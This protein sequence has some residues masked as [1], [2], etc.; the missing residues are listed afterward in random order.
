MK[1][2]QWSMAVV[3]CSVCV[4]SQALAVGSSLDG[5]LWCDDSQCK[6]YYQGRVYWEL[7][8]GDDGDWT[9]MARYLDN[10][11]DRYIEWADPMM[12]LMLSW[13]ATIGAYDMAQEEMECVWFGILFGIP[14]AFAEEYT[15]YATGFDPATTPSPWIPLRAGGAT[16]A[17]AATLEALAQLR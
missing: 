9:N 1:R 7:D 4:V 14:F 2:L 8:D 17:V 13:F 10:G 3:L 5:T 12:L 16:K 11:Q 15:L 6:G